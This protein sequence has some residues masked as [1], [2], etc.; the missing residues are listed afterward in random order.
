M[1]D[2]K[3]ILEKIVRWTKVKVRLNFLE[4]LVFP[5]EREIWWVSLGQNIGVEIN[6]K[7]ENFERPVLVV[8]RYNLEAF[9]V[10]P[11]SSKIKENQHCL[12]LIKNGSDYGTLNLS[13]IRSVSVK[14]FVRK[15]GKI[16]VVVYRD[17]KKRILDLFE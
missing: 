3:D 17:I 11:L 5:K 6:G 13:Q 12:S 1:L 4:K 10:I 2:Q 7:N 15:L 8:K 9:L 14:R 16:D